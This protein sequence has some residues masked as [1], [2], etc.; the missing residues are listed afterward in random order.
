MRLLIIGGTNFIGPALVRQLVDQ[1]HDL[2]VCHR[3][4]TERAL[5]ASVR[6][7]HD[8]RAGIPVTV[9]PKEILS[10]NFD[11]VVHMIAMGEADARSAVEAF[12]G[13]VPRLV[14]LSSGDVYRAYGRFTGLEP[15]S[16]EPGLLHESS[17]LR[18]VLY[19]YRSK[20]KS[21]AD[22]THDYEK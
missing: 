14:A 18:G 7:I 19:P 17:P 9:F 2:V 16:P 22:W 21:S 5:P 6:H 8:A 11:V 12:R 3:G 10:E 15:G 13:R 1:N 4:Q 20:A